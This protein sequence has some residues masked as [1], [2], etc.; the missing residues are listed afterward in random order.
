MAIFWLLTARMMSP[1]WKPTLAAVAAVG[2]IDHHD[3]LGL[4]IQ[5]QLV[6]KRRRDVGDLG[7]LERRARGEHD[8]VA[9]G[10]GRGLQRHRELHGLAGALHV[11]LRAEPPSGRVA[12]R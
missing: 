3:A 4:G 10:V 1:F 9:V 11:D 6:G 5:M 7:A 12:K 2:E 8:F